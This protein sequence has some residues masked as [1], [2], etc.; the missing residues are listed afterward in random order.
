MN[1]T[2]STKG[3]REEKAVGLTG[4]WETVSTLPRLTRLSMARH[5]FARALTNVRRAPL[6]SLL[7]IVTLSIALLLLA[8]FILGVENLNHALSAA[9]TELTLSIYCKDGTSEASARALMREL[10]ARP[11]VEH[12]RFL[13]K[14]QALAE[15]R[16]TLGER[17]SITE[18]L[19]DHNNPLPLT[20]ELR[21][22]KSPEVQ[23]GFEHIAAEYRNRSEVEFVQY[24]E[25]LLQNV[26]ALLRGVRSGGILATLVML[27]V[28]GFIISNTI[29]L[30]LYS[31]REEIEIMRLVGATDWFVRT[32]Y[33]IEGVAQGFV[34]GICSLLV[35]GGIFNLLHGALARSP[36]LSLFVP[37][38]QFLSWYWCLAIVA[39]GM[40]VGFAGSFLSVRRFSPE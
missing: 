1:S 7:T 29:K 11:E 15:F 9:Q 28:T 24:S 17:D 32:P 4:I 38:L 35:L 22:H 5:L 30:A 19:D 31:H 2:P 16:S 27:I 36:S 20:I 6:T 34:G 23:A 14:A 26:S 37:E 25:G 3:L 8:T 21:L 33:V 39:A 18:G 13:D 12:A 10:A 40:V